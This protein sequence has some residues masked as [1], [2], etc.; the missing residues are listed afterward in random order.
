MRTSEGGL[1]M[2]P[3]RADS[4]IA[5]EAPSANRLTEYDRAHLVTY[6]RL[7]DAMAEGAQ[8]SDVMRVVLGVDPI[9]EPER[10][11]RRFDSHLRRA[12]WMSSEGFRQLES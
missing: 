2:P 12:R 9:A 6:A 5:D 8:E 1:T 3:N 11:K 4:E 10:A 7:L